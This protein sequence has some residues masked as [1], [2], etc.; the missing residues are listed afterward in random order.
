MNGR[1]EFLVA[2]RDWTLFTQRSRH[3]SSSLA[4]GSSLLGK[5]GKWQHGLAA[6]L[7]AIY[8]SLN[9]LPSWVISCIND[10]DGFLH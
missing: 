9:F 8:V 2:N 1:S 4:S 5:A 6:S 3:F 10:D 7:L